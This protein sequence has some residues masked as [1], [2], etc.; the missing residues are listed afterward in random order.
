[1]KKIMFTI[2]MLIV[3]PIVVVAQMTT[4]ESIKVIE[5]T[6]FGYDFSN[7]SNVNRLNRIE[8]HLYGASKQ[9]SEEKRITDIQ[10]DIGFSVPTEKKQ[11]SKLSKKETLKEL[12]E[13]STV[14]YPI[15]DNMEQSIFD[16]TYSEENIYSR[17]NRL[18]ETVFNKVSDE[19]LNTRVDK[20]AAI[21]SPQKQIKPEFD[22]FKYQDVQSSYDSS[23]LDSV[24]DSS[25]PFQLA[26]METDLLNASFEKENNA[27]RLNR[28]E[29]KLFK[30]NYPNDSDITRMQR[31][32]VAYEAKK[33][34]FKYENNKKMQRMATASQIGG[35]L[36]M[37]LAMLL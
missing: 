17:L 36:L 1:M 35:I 12:K 19:D 21:I 13:D 18:E 15:V 9:G 10:N 24:T 34:S 28:L 7:E 23:G 6:M 22:D 29:E 31:I 30:R 5:N 4:T 20:L 3:S 14:D 27:R 8:K 16:T 37:I 25:F 32:L 11:E 26:S 2:L 33:D